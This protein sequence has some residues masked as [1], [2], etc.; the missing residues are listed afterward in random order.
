MAKTGHVIDVVDGQNVRLIEVGRGIVKCLVRTAVVYV[1]GVIIGV[2]KR[3][4]VG[5]CETILEATGIAAIHLD[6]QSVV[7]R[8]TAPGVLVNVAIT[9]IG[10]QEIAVLGAGGG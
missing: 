6:L 3:L 7:V 2:V 8:R 9:S 10:P 4:R 5:V 1:G